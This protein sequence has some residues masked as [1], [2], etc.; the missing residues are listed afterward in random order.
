MDIILQDEKDT[1]SNLDGEETLVINT[2][3]IEAKIN[4]IHLNG[5]K[6]KGIDMKEKYSPGNN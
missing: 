3:T 2:T 1:Q 5:T 6:Y 4:E